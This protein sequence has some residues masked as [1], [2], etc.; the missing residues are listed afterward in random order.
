M[1]YNKTFIPEDK[2]HKFIKDAVN[3][4]FLHAKISKTFED[5]IKEESYHNSHMISKND[6]K[7]FANWFVKEFQ[8]RFKIN[9]RRAEEEFSY[10]WI[11]W[12]IKT[13]YD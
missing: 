11:L 10:F 3:Q 13:E 12:G 1:K 6:E 9:R 8:N 7:R 5:A 4:M 2:K